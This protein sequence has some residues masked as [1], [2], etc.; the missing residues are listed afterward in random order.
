MYKDRINR[1]FT[2]LLERINPTEELAMNRRNILASNYAAGITNNLIGGNFFTG[3][4]LLLNADDAFIGL[5]TMTV[6]FGNMLQVLSPLILE[7]Y[8]N[9]KRLLVTGRIVIHFFNI[10][11]ISL[12]PLLT[13]TNSLKLSLI[14]FVV[15]VV[16]LMNSF[17]SP[18]Y[19]VWHIKSVPEAL[20]SRYFSFFHVT[21]GFIIYTVILFS[22]RVV[23]AFKQSGNEMTGLML[24]RWASLILAIV[25]VIFLCKVKE[26]PNQ[27]SQKKVNLVDVLLNPFKE[28]KYLLTV[29][30]A[31]LWSFAANIPGPYYNVYLLKDIGVSYSF[32][33]TVNMLSVP[34]MILVMPLWRKKIDTTSWFR[35]LYLCIGFFMIHYL[36]LAF[37]SERTLFLYPVFLVYAFMISPGLNLVFSNLPYMNIPE[38]GQTNYIGFY[39]SM[40]NMAAFLGVLLGREFI[41]HTNTLSIDILGISMG[42]KQLILILTA[43][44]MLVAVISI[45]FLSKVA[46][47]DLPQDQSADSSGRD[48]TLS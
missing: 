36:G 20:R 17:M 47:L 29:L 21:N 22:S 25:D 16:N 24:F 4:L 13:S 9:R 33:N 11:V 42:N 35:T 41:K 32:I 46:I 1:K 30:M 38:N 48:I 26:Y 31:C 45:F 40:N 37:V 34:I 7:R 10:I 8:A 15:L 27:L 6:M 3:L 28:H 2:S 14:L 23:D 5:V 18:G 39:A 12:I 19:Q 44:I 43:A